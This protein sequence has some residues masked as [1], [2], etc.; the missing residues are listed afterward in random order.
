VVDVN[1][2]LSSNFIPIILILSLLSE[3]FFDF[4][5]NKDLVIHDVV[6]LLRFLQCNSAFFAILNGAVVSTKFRHQEDRRHRRSLLRALAHRHRRGSIQH[7]INQ[8]LVND[9]Y[10]YR[11]RRNSSWSFTSRRLRKAK[12]SLSNFGC[13][14]LSFIV[15]VCKAFLVVQALV[16]NFFT[17]VPLWPQSLDN[18]R[19]LEGYLSEPQ[20]LNGYGFS[21]ISTI[22]NS[23]IES[24]QTW[25][26][27][28]CWRSIG[29]G[30][31]GWVGWAGTLRNK[32]NKNARSPAALRDCKQLYRITPQLDTTKIGKFCIKY[33]NN[34][35]KM[36]HLI[37][38]L[39]NI[40][41]NLNIIKLLLLI[42]GIEPNPGP[43]QSNPSIS[44]ISQNCRGLTDVKKAI[45]SINALKKVVTEAKTAQSI[46]LLQEC[47]EINSERLGKITNKQIISANGTR[48]SSG[49]AICLDE[50]SVL[51][52]NSIYKDPDGRFLICAIYNP[53]NEKLVTVI[54]N[55][56]AP[57]DHQISYDFFHGVIERIESLSYELQLSNL[58]Y[59]III[60]G[61][62]NCA[63]NDL[64]RGSS[65]SDM[66]KRLGNYLEISFSNLGCMDSGLKSQNKLNKSWRRQASW[67]RIDYIFMSK[68]LWD[69]TIA[70][71]TSWTVV[72]SDHA[73]INCVLG[74]R[75]NISPGRSFPKLYATELDNE[76]T[77]ALIRCHLE[78]E[79]QKFPSHWNPHQ[80]LEYIKIALRTKMLEIRRQHKIQNHNEAGFR[81]FDQ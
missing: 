62:F 50:E 24:F 60:G 46:I 4:V 2:L 30:R 48:S 56:Y 70:Y 14:Q 16:L 38:A 74:A 61:D 75:V 78:S 8:W 26:S 71:N 80:K 36:V 3:F 43:I 19:I 44:I 11:N 67:S 28:F 29:L 76:T 55:I 20:V 52:Q 51:V 1:K 37:F 5:F 9:L 35:I 72:H 12:S 34:Y 68:S 69:R 73:T 13:P 10:D 63:I 45:K 53:E 27:Y 22:V 59:E 21:S 65:R 77:K 54:G 7:A 79:I 81:L 6:F 57:N 40:H 15:K 58:E 64:D 31:A 39:L 41:Y 49:V 32:R 17:I 47:H 33:S 18:S 23:V 25:P 42:Q 66:E